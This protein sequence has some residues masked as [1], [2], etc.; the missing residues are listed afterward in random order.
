MSHRPT[1]M[2]CILD[3]LGLAALVLTVLGATL[4]G[5]KKAEAQQQPQQFQHFHQQGCPR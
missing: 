1:R 3:W 5:F 4:Y 2:H